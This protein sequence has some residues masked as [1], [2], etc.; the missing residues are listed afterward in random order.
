MNYFTHAKPVFIKDKSCE[1][2]YQAGF[3]CKFSAESGKKYSLVLSG[4]TLYR[5]TLNGN[6]IHYG[7][8]RGPHG[9]MRCDEIEL[10][11]IVGENTLAI[12]VAGYYCPS[13]YTLKIP[14]FIQA[15]L[16]ADGEC[17]AYTGRDFNGISITGL[18][19]QKVPRY[20]YQRAFTEV[21]YQDSPLAGWKN[22]DFDGEELEEIELRREY[23]ERGF[24]IPKFNITP[25]AEFTRA[26]NYKPINSAEL[27][28]ARYFNID[29]TVKGYTYSDCPNDVIRA[30]DSTFTADSSIDA[31]KL[32]AGQFAEYKFPHISAGFIRTK[33]NAV[34]PS[35]IYVVFAEQRLSNGNIHFG[36]GTKS[37]LNIIKYR[38]PTGIHELE[39]F[40]CYSFK[41]IGILVESGSIEDCE[42]TLREYCYP[43]KP[44]A[45]KTG[46]EKLD[47]LISAAYEGFRQNT[48]DCFMDC[49]GRERAGWLCD[50]FFT[51]KTSFLFTGSIDCEKYFLDNFRLNKENPLPLGLLPECYPSENL[52]YETIPQWTMWYIMEL[53]GFEERG[54]DTAP[55]AQLVENTVN[56]FA[57]FENSD[58]LLEKLPF[59][60]FVEWTRAN[61]WVQD[62]NYPTN[63]LYCGMLRVAA[64][65]LS[66]P[67]LNK[68]ADKIRNEI[69]RQSFDGK[70]F[71]DHAI[72]N[73]NGELIVQEDRSA[74]CQHEA[75]FFD[76]I[77]ANA[78][79]YTEFTKTV[80]EKLGVNGDIKSLDV[81][82]EPLDLFIGYAIRVETMMKL[83]YYKQNLEEIKTL[84]APMAVETGTFWETLAGSESRNHGFASFIAYVI[85]E[86]LRKLRK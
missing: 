84:Y 36:N 38:L 41:Y 73:E 48:V 6:F 21:W 9:Y 63:M 50:S 54:G 83:G 8:A 15:E 77:D 24:A 28:L 20:S 12:E 45:L 33:I 46:D 17:I 1:M 62:V 43:V 72:R 29:D 61:N 44:L 57:G 76:I 32:N 78:P 19:E 4:A 80:I 40:E 58:G 35:T 25:A 11:P 49:P 67:E 86:C 30:T 70:L 23:I 18:R 31:S 3:V 34:K 56:Y 42:F 13:F 7:P 51:G 52:A 60:N 68:K 53:G 65:I 79:E 81:E 85:L 55:F 82:V 69:V 64:K 26:G 10:K 47:I 74:I 27:S 39:S 59:W 66:K 75:M 16:S 22:G 14:S 71:R 2:N 5:V 37:V